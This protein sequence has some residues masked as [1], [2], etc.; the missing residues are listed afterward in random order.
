MHLCEPV[1]TETRDLRGLVEE[2]RGLDD[3]AP[4]EHADTNGLRVAGYEAVANARRW[5]RATS[6]ARGLCVRMT[7]LGFVRFYEAAAAR[8]NRGCTS[9]G[10]TTLRP[11]KEI[12]RH[13]GIQAEHACGRDARTDCRSA[14]ELFCVA[15]WAKRH[16]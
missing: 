2:L 16:A 9:R 12:A 14:H 10:H 5:A 6:V 15:G 8:H 1:L 4:H 13:S 7:S 11:C 3:P